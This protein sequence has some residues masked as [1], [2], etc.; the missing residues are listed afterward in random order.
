MSGITISQQVKV[1]KAATKTAAKSKESALQFLRDAGIAKR[2]VT[3]KAT[4]PP[5][6]H[7]APKK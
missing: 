5:A 6:T 7:S 3:H 2:T 4:V 1:I